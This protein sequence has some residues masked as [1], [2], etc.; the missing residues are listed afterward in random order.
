MVQAHAQG[1]HVKVCAVHPRLVER[2]QR[3]VGE[4]GGVAG[5]AVPLNHYAIDALAGQEVGRRGPY[6]PS[7]DYHHV[8]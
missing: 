8:R 5:D 2:A 1:G 3:G 4:A 6:Q 7:T